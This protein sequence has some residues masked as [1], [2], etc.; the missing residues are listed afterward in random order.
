[1]KQFI[2]TLYSYDY[3]GIGPEEVDEVE[4]S[5]IHFAVEEK[6]AGDDDCSVTEKK[7]K[8][9]RPTIIAYSST[10]LLYTSPSPRDS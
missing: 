4:D 6:E 7:Q 2:I 10:C 1:M 3:E 8:R 5:E 9:R